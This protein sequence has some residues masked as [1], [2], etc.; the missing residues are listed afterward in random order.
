MFLCSEYI[1][2]QLIHLS[3]GVLCQNE[4][5]CVA[6]TVYASFVLCIV[7]QTNDCVIIDNRKTFS[8]S[9]GFL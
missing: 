7:C 8:V 5:V 2:V 1:V 9:S 6:K 3:A 4:R